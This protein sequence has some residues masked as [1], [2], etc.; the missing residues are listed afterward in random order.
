[1]LRCAVP[2][3]HFEHSWSVA[4]LLGDVVAHLVDPFSYVGLSPLVVA[5]RDVHAEADQASYVAVERF[6]FGPLRWDNHIQVRMNWSTPPDR[7]VSLVI[8]PG[9]VR[10]K[11]VV[12]LL[13]DGGGTAVRETIEINSPALLRKFVLGK[14]T[15]VQQ[16]RAAELTRRMGG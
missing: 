2:I 9:G 12:E 1:M 10:L 14:A 6:R 8:S 5:V 4:A 15:A 3:D 7:I 13:P 11:S 16:Q